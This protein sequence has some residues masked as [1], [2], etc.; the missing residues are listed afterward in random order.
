MAVMTTLLGA[1]AP[2]LAQKGFDILSG[3]F[4]SASKKGGNLAEGLVKKQIDRIAQKIEDK[5]G[6]KLDDIADDKLTEEQW[7]QLKE[8]ELQ[9]QELILD[10]RNHVAEIDL[11]SEKAHLADIQSARTA[12]I[13]RD[14]NEDQF[15]RRFTYWYAYLIT[16][17]TFSFIIFAIALPILFADQNNPIPDQAWQ[18]VNTVIGFLLGV[19]LSAIIQYYYGSSMGSKSKDRALFGDSSDDGR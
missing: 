6:I 16:G 4:S 9:E 19:G 1:I 17:I 14:A 18:I 2:K 13:S 12:G 8:F 11:E 7:R 10:A 15:I 3:L 5:T